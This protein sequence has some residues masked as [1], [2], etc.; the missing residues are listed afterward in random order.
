MDLLDRARDLLAAHPVV[1]GH[2]DLPWALRKQVSYDLNRLDI[3]ADQ[4]DRL[5]TDIPLLAF[6][7][8]P[9]VRSQLALTWGTETFL[10]PSFDSTDAMVG[11][12]DQAMLELGTYSRGDLVIIVAGSPPRT[13]GSTNLIHVH[14][15]GED[16]H[17]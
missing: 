14:R 7:P 2:N 10:V 4:S 8:E 16:D 11:Q 17:R 13:V 15:L 6:T 12:V 5:H 9:G 3:A 1:D